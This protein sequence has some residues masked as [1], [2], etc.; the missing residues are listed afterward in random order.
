MSAADFLAPEV[1]NS[2]V[3][4]E[5][6]MSL[7]L[8]SME[9]AIAPK[10]YEEVSEIR[11]D[12][13]ASA[14]RQVVLLGAPASGADAV[15]DFLAALPVDTRLFFLHTQPLGGGSAEALVANLAIHSALPVRLATQGSRA[16]N[17]EVLVVP[18]GQQ[19][20]LRRDGLVD[21]QPGNEHSS[22]EPSIDA[23]FS[24]AAGVFT[25]D[26]LAIVFA[27]RGNDGVAGSQAVKDRGGKVWVES[28][29]GE[30]S[31]DIVSGIVAE[32]LVS[33]SGSPH[34]L[35]AHLSE[36]YP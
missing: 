33:F 17:G 34:E 16:K 32:R 31:A 11:L 36:V 23:T 14:L 26:A 2:D 8:I 30:H 28:S 22:G 3:F 5:P 21:L 29:S 20:R 19:L 18:P 27:G 15:C 9:E 24:M 13:S 7:D 1:E 4:G 12:E 6:V 25:R 35:A 10:L